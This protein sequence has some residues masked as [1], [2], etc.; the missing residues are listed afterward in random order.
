[1]ATAG[2]HKI[3]TYVRLSGMD[4]LSVEKYM[5]LF[6]GLFI[7][8]FISQRTW[9]F[10]AM[11]FILL[12]SFFQ[13]AHLEFYGLPIYPGEFL[14]A[15][16]QGGE[17]WGTLKEELS[18]FVLPSLIVLLPAI[19]LYFVN[20]KTTKS[21][22]SRFMVY[23]FIFY[24][25]FN[26][27]RTFV[28]G[29]NWGR[30][31]SGEEFEGMNIYLSA[32]YFLGKILPAKL[33][34][35]H[36]P[37]KRRSPLNFI[38]KHHP[39]SNI[40]FVLGE[41]LTPNH[42]SLFGYQRR[43]TPFLNK[44]KEDPN[45][46]YLEGLSS[47]VSSDVSV[48]F[49]MNNTFG[50]QG[51]EDVYKGKNCL[52]RLAKEAGFSTHYYSTQSNQQLRY[53]RNSI[54]PKYIDD[55]ADLE[56]IDSSI[57]DKD[58][59]RD[60]L[61]LDKLGSLNLESGKK[62]I[63]LHQRGSHSPYAKRFTEEFNVFKSK[64]DDDRKMRNLNHYDNSVLEFDHFYKNLISFI[65]KQKTPTYVVFVS[66]HG[67][68]LG[69]EGV[70]GHGKLN[71]I[72]AQVPLLVYYHNVESGLPLPSKPTHFHLSLFLTEL[73]GYEGSF[74]YFQKLDEYIIYGND[75]DGF[76]GSLKVRDF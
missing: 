63:L 19:G 15:F 52:F 75:I 10:F 33:A 62:F 32:S 57:D 35:T 20:K 18:I 64:S 30:Q 11:G 67:E 2:S 69:E 13:F 68:G 25:I 42:M 45:F 72:S 65:K 73:M 76:M 49:L 34:S 7:F 43:T 41:S 8:S 46:H 56:K 55:Y 5:A 48:A 71:M 36:P 31:P 37:I 40:I 12:L 50:D 9:R 26:P 44:L 38:K 58:T 27:M 6:V 39:K 47:G 70:Y 3:Y 16:T 60:L 61:L 22:G 24:L 53:I 66:D 21:V 4:T 1:M 51:R 54:C 17:I 29:N 74:R 14:L 28:T 23:L 59:A